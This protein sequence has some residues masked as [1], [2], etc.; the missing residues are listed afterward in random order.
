MLDPPAVIIPEATIMSTVSDRGRRVP[1]PVALVHDQLVQRGGAERVTLL[2]T[3]A[4]PGA[5][6]F[7][8]FYDVSRTFPEFARVDVHPSPL[9]RVA[10]LRGHVRAALPLMAFAFSAM[11]PSASVTLCSSTGW[12]HGVRA[13]GRKVVYCHAPARWLYQTSRYLRSASAWPSVA[14]IALKAL[15]R[16]LRRWDQRAAKTAHRYLANSTAT[17]AAVL[18]VYGTEAEVLPPPPALVPGGEE[19]SVASVEPGYWLCV[20]RLLPYKNVDAVVEAVRRRPEERLVVVG[21]GPERATL[22]RRSGPQVQFLGAV[23]DEELRWLYRNCR[24][25]L[26]ASYEDFGLT[27]LEAASFGRPSAVLR[28]G[29]FLD[30]L[31]DGST[32]VFFDEPEPGAIAAAMDRLVALDLKSDVLVAHAALFG[33]DRFIARLRQVVH[34]ELEHAS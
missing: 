18:A 4:F 7:T 13:S 12:S 28:W 20:S 6:L 26:S 11:H 17:A 34:E 8:S 33:R 29:G 25:L 24:G 14:G 32:G 9:N 23:G 21:D 1:V 10:W 5:P 19:R 22:E 27:P 2:M 16:P 31:H 15:G 30:T 3:D